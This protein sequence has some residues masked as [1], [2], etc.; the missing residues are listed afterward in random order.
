M[1]LTLVAC[2]LFAYGNW[3][4]D[5]IPLWLL[6]AIFF[7][8]PLIPWFAFRGYQIARSVRRFN[9]RGKTKAI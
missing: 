8:A 7:V 6:V 3:N 1:L 4:L 2:V 9:L 5:G